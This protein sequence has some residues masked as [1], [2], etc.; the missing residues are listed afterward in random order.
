[1]N[2]ILV[3][4]LTAATLFISNV[5]AEPL[6]VGSDDTLQTILTA[7]KGQRVTLRLRSGSE[8]TGKAGEV[9]A[10]IVHL[11]EL[12][13]KEFFD[14]VVPLGKIEAVVIRTRRQ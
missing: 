3:I 4:T 2:R 8:L 12:S 1:M 6:A 9:N 14:A 11:M 10:E 7:Y 13:G 5:F